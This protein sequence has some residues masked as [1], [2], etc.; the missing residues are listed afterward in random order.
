MVSTIAMIA[1]T[2]ASIFMQTS[3]VACSVPL[4]CYLLALQSYYLSCS[5]CSLLLMCHRF[6]V[7]R[8]LSS[9]ALRM[10]AALHRMFLLVLGLKTAPHSLQLATDNRSFVSTC[11]TCSTLTS[12]CRCHLATIARISAGLIIPSQQCTNR[13]TA[14]RFAKQAIP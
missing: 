11:F 5:L 12:P 2:V 10:H 6:A 9:L 8:L 3:V 13:S 7:A 1:N 14:C 4:L